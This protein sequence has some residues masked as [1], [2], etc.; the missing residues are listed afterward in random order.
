MNPRLNIVGGKVEP[1]AHHAQ[2]AGQDVVDLGSVP[3]VVGVVVAGPLLNLLLL[4]V[5]VVVVGSGRVFGRPPVL[6]GGPIG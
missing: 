6:K 3:V 4:A 5:V 1:L 2:Q